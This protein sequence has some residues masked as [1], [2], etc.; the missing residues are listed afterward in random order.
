M[1]KIPIRA[2]VTSSSPC[3]AQTGLPAFVNTR[4]CFKLTMMLI[5]FMASV[6][7]TLDQICQIVG[8]LFAGFQFQKLS[9]H[10]SRQALARFLTFLVTVFLIISCG[11]CEFKLSIK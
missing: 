6:Y 8:L 5:D 11:M 4:T 9:S 2:D 1:Y 7:F 10:H 3:R